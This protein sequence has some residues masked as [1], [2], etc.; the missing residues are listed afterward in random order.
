MFSFI[1]DLPKEYINSG[2][3]YLWILWKYA[4]F[5]YLTLILETLW[6]CED[7]EN[8]IGL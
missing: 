1:C 3:K 7:L 6:K 4:L 5:P 2:N 8:H